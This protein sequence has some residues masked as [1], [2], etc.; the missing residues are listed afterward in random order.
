MNVEPPFTVTVLPA[1]VVGLA[2][3]AGSCRREIG[4]RN[5]YLFCLGDLLPCGKHSL[6]W[7]FIIQ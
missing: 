2:M 3:S 4:R 1:W 7:R 5:V 6:Q